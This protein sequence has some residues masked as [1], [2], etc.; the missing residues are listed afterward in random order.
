MA[1]H[2]AFKAWRD[3]R[4]AQRYGACRRQLGRLE[5]DLA[6][7]RAAQYKATC[8]P[9]CM[10][11]FAPQ[12]P[13]PGSVAAGGPDAAEA[14]ASGGAA[15][16][17]AAAQPA[18]APAAPGLVPELLACGHTFCRP[19][20][21]TWLRSSRTCPI[22]RRPADGSEPAPAPR[23]PGAPPQSTVVSRGGGWDAFEPEYAFRLQRLHSRYPQFVTRSLADEWLSQGAAARG[24]TVQPSFVARNPELARSAASGGGGHG[25]G[26]SSS[27]F[28]GGSSRDGGGSGSSW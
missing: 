28:G 27:S 26:G 9:V 13:E 7:A 8:C 20:L 19:C 6:K 22:C 18:A 4:G 5:E 24:L 16:A 15:D 25:S 23:E 14:A 17:A 11:D 1:A 3:H 12:P 2:A 10:E 21:E